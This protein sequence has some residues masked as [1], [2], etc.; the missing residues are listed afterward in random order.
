MVEWRPGAPQARHA[1]PL[2]TRLR[3]CV[4]DDAHP[5]I[6]FL[7]FA[8]L[9]AKFA[10]LSRMLLLA[11]M[12][13][14][15][16]LRQQIPSPRA[17]RRRIK[18]ALARQISRPEWASFARISAFRDRKFSSEKKIVKVWSAPTRMQPGVHERT[19]EVSM[20][21]SRACDDAADARGT[22]QG[23]RIHL[24]GARGATAAL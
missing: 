24:D 14:T 6:S 16:L 21:V 15:S 12:A 20:R 4:R 23:A 11:P 2:R 10:K 1:P 3:R 13:S 22:F 5:Q 7:S 19:H 9:P 8:Q 18:I 17:R